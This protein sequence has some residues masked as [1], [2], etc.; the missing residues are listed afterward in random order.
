M[1]NFILFIFSILFFSNSCKEPNFI[2]LHTELKENDVA[3]FKWILKVDKSDSNYIEFQIVK[4]KE[5]NNG[6]LGMLNE[7]EKKIDYDDF[8]KIKDNKKICRLKSTSPKDFE[9]GNYY[10]TKV[11]RNQTEVFF[12]KSNFLKILDFVN[13]EKTLESKLSGL[14]SRGWAIEKQLKLTYKISL[15]EVETIDYLMNNNESFENLINS[16][17]RAEFR[18]IVGR[19]KKEDIDTEISQID[20]AEKLKTELKGITIVDLKLSN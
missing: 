4:T 5:L 1:K 8:V 17:I 9:I 15:N 11:Y 10:Y 18:S 16:K 19:T 2:T 13:Q 7:F 14:S 12:S 3:E 20:L 6:L